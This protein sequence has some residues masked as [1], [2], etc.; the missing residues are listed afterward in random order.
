MKIRVSKTIKDVSKTIKNE[1]KEQKDGFLG[2]LLGILGAN[3][4]GNMIA[5]KDVLR[6]GGGTIRSGQ[7]F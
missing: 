3:L 2:V 5:G 4:L 1:A 7:N 6:A